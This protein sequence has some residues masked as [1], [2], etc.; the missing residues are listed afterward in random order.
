LTV[1]SYG[2]WNSIFPNFHIFNLH[3]ETEIPLTDRFVCETIPNVNHLCTVSGTVPFLHRGDTNEKKKINVSDNVTIAAMAVAH[4]AA[5]QRLIPR[6]TARTAEK[7]IRRA[8][9]QTELD[10]IPYLSCPSFSDDRLQTILETSIWL[11]SKLVPH[12]FKAS[13][14]RVAL[15]QAFQSKLD[16]NGYCS[17]N[18][19]ALFQAAVWEGF[20]PKLRLRLSKQ[21]PEPCLLDTKEFLN[22]PCATTMGEDNY[23]S[24]FADA[25]PVH[26]AAIEFSRTK[27]NFTSSSSSCVPS[28]VFRAHHNSGTDLA[29][30][31]MRNVCTLDQSHSKEKSFAF[32]AGVPHVHFIRDP[33][34]LIISG[35]Q[36]H[37][38]TSEKWVITS[39]LQEQLRN[40]SIED[41]LELQFQQSSKTLKHMTSIYNMSL[42]DPD[43]FF[44]IRLEHIRDESPFQSTMA[45]L[46]KWL[47][48]TDKVSWKQLEKCCFV[49]S[50][51]RS[52]D[53]K[54]ELRRIVMRDNGDSI[55]YWRE[56]LGFPSIGLEAEG[57]TNEA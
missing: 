31:L 26:S 6:H 35:Y 25:V 41:G 47:G 33:L 24:C 49:S 27:N 38:I 39:G 48:K 29:S 45:A 22:L 51:E 18:T 13:G 21:A 52:K 32:H 3:E 50:A 1:E 53:D 14:G 2:A 56:K 37:L 20:L 42:G 9:W 40:A 11:E 19:T 28:V 5:Q 8:F 30:S 43:D 12:F 54:A 36:D 55:R 16:N 44:T 15:E 10:P 34:E 4:A 17:I 57:E 46:Q 7:V 23:Q